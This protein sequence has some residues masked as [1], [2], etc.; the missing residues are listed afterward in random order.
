MGNLMMGSAK[1]KG[2]VPLM[3]PEQQ[4]LMGQG[5]QGL[6]P[7]V[8]QAFAQGIGPYD[9]SQFQDLFQQ[10]FIDPAMQVYEQQALPAIQQRF[11]DV[12]A[13]SSSALNQALGQ[14]A[15]DLS[16]ML[17]TQ[18]GQ[19]YQQQQGNQQN[20]LQMLMGTLGQRAFDPIIQQQQGLAGPLIGAAG[21]IGGGY[22]AG[23]SLDPLMKLI[24]G[25][26][27]K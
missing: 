21:Q 13:G 26:G 4:Q 24:A 9:P 15:A 22:M 7:Q 25:I 18:M 19:F 2:N 1:H 12:G 23:R 8:N 10:A 6:G 16:T 3:T 17:G 11:V 27:G 5:I 20:M 14:S